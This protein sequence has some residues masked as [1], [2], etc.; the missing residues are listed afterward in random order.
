MLNTPLMG[1]GTLSLIMDEGT[2][3]LI[4]GEGTLG[5]IGIRVNPH[6]FNGL[7]DSSEHWPLVNV[8]SSATAMQH[9]GTT[10]LGRSTGAHIHAVVGSVVPLT[11]VLI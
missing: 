5:L 2:L 10:K 9:R 11:R 3:S 4:M 1:E 6:V 8:E 7:V